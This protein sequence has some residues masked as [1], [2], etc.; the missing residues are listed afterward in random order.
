MR[1]N[2]Y[3]ISF[4][5]CLKENADVRRMK[6]RQRKNKILNLFLL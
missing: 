5:S 6:N 2:K 4:L 3:A 1:K